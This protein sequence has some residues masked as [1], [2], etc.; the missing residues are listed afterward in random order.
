[1]GE[2]DGWQGLNCVVVIETEE[3]ICVVKWQTEKKT[4]R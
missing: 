4:T 3:S 2:C 1:M